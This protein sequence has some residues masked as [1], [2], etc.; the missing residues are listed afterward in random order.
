VGK[1]IKYFGISLTVVALL[2]LLT[3]CQ[4]PASSEFTTEE[5][6]TIFAAVAHQ[7]ATVD[8]TFGGQLNPERLFIISSTNDDA[9]SASGEPSASRR[10]S[11]TAQDAVTAALDSLQAEIIWID[12]FEDAE[13]EGG[14]S[15]VKNGVII[16]LGNIHPQENGSVWVSGSIYIANMAAGGTT[17]VL[18]KSGNVW[19][20]TGTTGGIWIS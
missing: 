4:P 2:V 16:T 10:I 18:E 9:G 20:I 13:F 3:S 5:E 6:A 14:G 11:N 8:D 17:Y 12:T 1:W 15:Q 19:K 7:L